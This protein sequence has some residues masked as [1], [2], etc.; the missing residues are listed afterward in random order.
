MSTDRGAF[1][2]CLVSGVAQALVAQ[3]FLIRNRGYWLET[4]PNGTNPIEGH[5]YIQDQQIL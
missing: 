3:S 4:H 5:S 1:P 2:G